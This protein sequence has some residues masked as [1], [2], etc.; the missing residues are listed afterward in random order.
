MSPVITG[1]GLVTPLGLTAQDNWSAL[2][3]GRHITGHA[4]LNAWTFPCRI[5]QISRAAALQAMA[6]A[7]WGEELLCDPATAIVTGTSKGDIEGMISGGKPS[8]PFHAYSIF[9][10]PVF[11]RHAGPRL[12][13]CAA[14]ASGLHALIRAA[15]LLRSGQAQRALVIAADAA[16]HP[17]FLA[18][19]KRLG[20]LAP[21]QIGCRPFDLNRGGFVMS[22][23]AAA[24]CL[25][26]PSATAAPP[27]AAIERFALAAD[28]HHLTGGDPQAAALCR[29]I[30]QVV[31]DQPVD[32]VHA[33]GT[34]TIY[35]DA[36]ELRALDAALGDHAP[37]PALYS[38]KAAIGH[39]L[40]ASGLVS[41]VL[42]SLCHGRGEIPGNINTLTPMPMGRLMLDR[43]PVARRVGRSLALAAGFGGAMAAVTLR[44]L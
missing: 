4:R 43:S 7:R 28:A 40:G 27:I 3:A 18:S 26:P 15:M 19:F 30:K 42:N 33:H 39:S 17:L 36:A 35:N 9:Q 21:P 16:V 20:V 1:L 29:L 11:H 44:S 38:H 24:V 10:F 23:T 37:P 8:Q 13:L 22:E 41:V 6:Q 14:C 25:E 12:T 32:L 34:G 31:Q 2:L 5:G